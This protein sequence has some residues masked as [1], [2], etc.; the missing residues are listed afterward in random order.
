MSRILVHGLGAVSPAGWGVAALR[1]ALGKNQPCPTAALARPGWKNN[2]SVRAVPPP[3]TRPAILAHPRLRRAIPMAQHV[4]A[5]ASE[6]LGNDATLVQAGK[7]RL[8]LV[9]CLLAGC[10]SYSRRFFEEVLREPAT[11]SPLIFPETVFNAPAS[12]LA[13]VFGS[14]GISYSIVGDDGA[15]LQGLALGAQWLAQGQVE[16]C[17]VIG[18]EELDWVVADAWR[19]FHR[20][21]PLSAGAGAVYLKLEPK[22]PNLRASANTGPGVE[23]ACV[24]DSFSF[25]TVANRKVAARKMRAQLPASDAAELLCLSARE[26]P[27]SDAAELAAWA[28]WPGPRLAPRRIFGEAFTASAAWQ[29]V[30]ACEAVRHGG[31]TAANV[32]VVGVNQ[33]AIGARFLKTDL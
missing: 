6:A 15:F 7:L 18:A 28:D 9:V 19:L 10:V 31:F 24:T 2:L 12:H 13:A 8:G 16:G 21:S 29:C 20:A 33:Q 23:L 11:A 26:V 3:E 1:D 5:A 14:N 32:S 22:N 25:T 27:R 4:V 30:A 17:L